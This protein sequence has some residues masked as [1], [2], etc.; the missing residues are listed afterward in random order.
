MKVVLM[1]DVA[2]LGFKGDVVSVSDGYAR[3][4]L[5]PQNLAVQAT[6]VALKK[7]E[8]EK[9]TRASREKK[10]MKQAGQLAKKLDDFELILEEK[11]SEEGTLYAAVGSVQIVKALK[12]AGLE[13]DPEWIDLPDPIKEVGESELTINLPHGFE[14][15]IKIIIETKE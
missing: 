15:K 6:P 1:Q 2:K 7:V 5:F 8:S 14:A 12:K 9:N 11:A 13:V 10:V 3:N 4:L